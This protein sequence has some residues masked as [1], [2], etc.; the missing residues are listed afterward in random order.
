[1]KENEKYPLKKLYCIRSDEKQAEN[2]IN[3]CDFNTTS[4]HPTQKSC[5]LKPEID[6]ME[7]LS[8]NMVRNKQK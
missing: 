3:L 6:P 2:R 7:N 8:K 4:P 1:M 5:L